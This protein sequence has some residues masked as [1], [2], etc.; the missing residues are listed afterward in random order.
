MRTGSPCLRMAEQTGNEVFLHCVSTQDAANSLGMTRTRFVT[1]ANVLHLPV[2]EQSK[3]Q[4]GSPAKRYEQRDI[5][6]LRAL[7]ERCAIEGGRAVLKRLLEPP[8]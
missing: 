7:C 8:E 2:R 3:P 1:I 6:L 4:G 5:D